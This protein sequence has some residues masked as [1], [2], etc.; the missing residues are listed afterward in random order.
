MSAGTSGQYSVELHVG[1]LVEARV[2][3]LATVQEVTAYIAAIGMQVERLHRQVFQDPPPALQHLAAALSA[4]ELER[5]S[6]FL[7]GYLG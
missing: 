4:E 2:H 5:A 6:D 1:R 3:R 7:A